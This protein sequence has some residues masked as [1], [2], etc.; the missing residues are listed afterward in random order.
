MLCW[1]G[2]E[3]TECILFREVRLH[4]T[5][6]VV[7]GMILNYIWLWAF[8]YVDL[9]NVEYPFIVFTP[10]IT[11]ILQINPTLGEWRPAFRKWRK[12]VT[13]SRL[14]IGHVMLIYPFILKQKQQAQ[15]LTCQTPGAVK[16][17]LI[18]CRDFTL[19]KKRFFKVNISNN[20]F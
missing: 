2:Y 10:S 12:K 13:I 5:K 15:W 1:W 11:L 20:L 6:K 4:S 14:L 16:Y 9:K 17:V 19:V 18:E 8:S 7:L 3:Y